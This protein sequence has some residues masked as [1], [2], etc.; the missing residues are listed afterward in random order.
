MG[1][2]TSTGITLGVVA[3]TPATNDA[4]GFGALTFVDVGEVIDLPEYGPNVQVV[5]F[6]PL[7]TGVN[8]KLSGF[9]NYGSLAICLE[10]AIEND[11]H[12]VL[13]AGVR[14]RPAQ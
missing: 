10:L 14:G 11:R 7:A 9:I 3:S 12:Q 8:Q 6:Q 4:A 5:E 2:M 1:K 13:E